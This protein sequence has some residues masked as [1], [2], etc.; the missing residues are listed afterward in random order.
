MMRKCIGID[1][2]RVALECLQ[3]S[4]SLSVLSV[5]ADVS[6]LSLRESGKILYKGLESDA[7][8][9]EFTLHMERDRDLAVRIS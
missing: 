3:G 2:A 9:L 4:H 8:P 7:L 5:D 6:G 1:E